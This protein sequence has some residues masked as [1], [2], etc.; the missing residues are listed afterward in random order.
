MTCNWEL[1]YFSIAPQQRLKI[2]RPH[3]LVSPVP[4]TALQTGGKQTGRISVVL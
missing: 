1:G 4:V 2:L 3:R